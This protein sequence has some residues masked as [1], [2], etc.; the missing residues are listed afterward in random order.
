MFVDHNVCCLP[1]AL[2]PDGTSGRNKKDDS[3]GPGESY[4]YTWSVTEEFAPTKSDPS[5]LTWIYH[6]H[7]DAPKDIA[8]G[9][10]GVLLT[11]NKG[12]FRETL[13]QKCLS[14]YPYKHICLNTCILLLS[15]VLDNSGTRRF[16][17]DQEF[18][19]MF[20]VVDENLSWYLKNNIERFIPDAV[21]LK[22]NEEFHESNLMHGKQF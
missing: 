7:V 15:G 8:S 19:L 20:S 6:S 10:I 18:F 2:Y 3:V 14:I 22:D 5:C 17:V 11:C 21:N 9:L 16:D 4:T 1:G 12:K 13:T